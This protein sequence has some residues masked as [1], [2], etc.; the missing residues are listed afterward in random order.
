MLAAV[1]LSIDLTVAP[2]APQQH[3][4]QQ[5]SQCSAQRSNICNA[6]RSAESL[7]DA[8]RTKSIYIAPQHF[9]SAQPSD[10][11]SDFGQV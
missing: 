11:L 1:P 9:I 6:S 7:H 10:A 2:R 5:D 8:P 3:A 4:A